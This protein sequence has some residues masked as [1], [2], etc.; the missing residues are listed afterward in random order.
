MKVDINKL[1]DIS[2]QKGYKKN[3][4]A[5]LINISYWTLRRKLKTDGKKFSLQDV[6]NLI[7]VLS[8]SKEQA[9]SIFLNF[10]SETNKKEK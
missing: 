10:E 9:V 4:L 1:L 3:Y 7:D 5:K 2:R 6:Y 8:L